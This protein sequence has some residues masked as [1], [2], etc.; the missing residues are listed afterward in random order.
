MKKGDQKAQLKRL[1]LSS[2]QERKCFKDC[3]EFCNMF[4]WNIFIQSIAILKP[5]TNTKPP[6]KEAQILAPMI[7]YINL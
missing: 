3:A 7:M 5:Y 1:H 4:D 2:L 6:A